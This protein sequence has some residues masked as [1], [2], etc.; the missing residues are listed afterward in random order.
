MTRTPEIG[1]I[2]LGTMGA[3]LALNIAEAGHVIAVFNR[4]S[5]RTRRFVEGAG[6]LADRI[7]PAET[8]NAFVDGLARPRRILLM[9]PAG[10]PV[11]EQIA[12]LRPL[13][14]TGDILIDGGNSDWQDSA[15]R[16][17]SLQR[18]GL[19]YLGL[20]V[21][22]GAEGARHGPSM[23]AGG[24]PEAYAAVGPILD[25]IAARFDATPCVAWLGHGGAGHFV[26]AVHNG[27]E[28]ADMQ[29]I[30]EVYGLMRDGQRRPDAE[31]AQ[32]FG[33][34]NAGPLE[35]YL[36]EI[37][38]EVAG[39]TDPE[40]GKPILSLIRDRAGQKGTGRW[41]VMDAQRRAAPLPAVEAAVTAR[42][43]S[44]EDAWRSAGA[45]LFPQPKRAIALPDD[46]FE[47]AL[48][49]GKILAYSQGFAL[50]A[51]AARDE[52]WD[53]SLAMVAQIWRAGCI[54]RSGLLDEMADALAQDGP[55][56]LLAFAPG[57]A[58]RLQDGVPALRR[59]VAEATLAG[60]P[61]P[62]LSAALGHFDQLRQA[63]GTANLIQ[64]LRDRFGAHGFERLDRP[65]ETGL[66]GPWGDA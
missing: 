31:I 51:R 64:G 63:R 30:A 61:V 48:L 57:F 58:R 38:A 37:T 55:D 3:N 29:M 66:H 16:A 6:P 47:R 8:L 2:G 9:V 25:D 20:G 54:I 43:L 41:T 35:S 59:V 15:A 45:R 33:R 42:V 44:G 28:Y 21:S 40:T 52:G 39:T 12:A 18:D 65:G 10:A 22:G 56:S 19:G 13:L 36:I 11:D 24:A 7:V 53:M 60:V 49:A 17:E 26:K 23:M 4:T 50:L 1:L 27:I 46:N 14:D 62:A 5:D 34:W 32:V